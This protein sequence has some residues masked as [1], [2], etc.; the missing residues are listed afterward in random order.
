MEANEEFRNDQESIKKFKSEGD[1]KVYKET[2]NGEIRNFI[3]EELNIRTTKIVT[4]ITNNGKEIKTSL[5]DRNTEIYSITEKNNFKYLRDV[6]VSLYF[7]NQASKTI[8][9]RKMG[10]QPINYGNV[11]VSIKMDSGYTL[12]G[13]P[14]MIQWV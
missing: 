3:F 2:V 1:G 11:F 9:S 14:V 6:T 5:I 8:F 13:N 4:E 12:L 10:E 7:L